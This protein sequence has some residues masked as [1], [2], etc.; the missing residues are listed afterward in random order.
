[1]S[2]RE[3]N[4]VDHAEA[5]ATSL[6]DRDRTLVAMRSVEQ[7]LARAAGREKWQEQVMA[8]LRDLEAA[9]RSEHEELKRPD[10]LLALITGVHPRL[11]GPRIR[12]FNEQYDDISRQTASLRT[13]V[14]TAERDDLDP[15]HLRHRVGWILNALNHCRAR[16]TDLVFEAL[17]L[18]L[19]AR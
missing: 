9:M 18:D 10:S 12:S 15:D 19:G 3:S 2:E 6:E 5:F 14:E 1:M 17:T 7:A 13:Q 16:Q 4:R 8:A 11:F